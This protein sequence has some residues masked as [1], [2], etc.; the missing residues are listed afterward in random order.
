MPK[1][2]VKICVLFPGSKN[3]TV[4]HLGKNGTSIGN[5]EC[6][7]G[8]WISLSNTQTTTVIVRYI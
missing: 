1:E 5:V 3:L 4:Q 7:C 8:D 2:T 6:V